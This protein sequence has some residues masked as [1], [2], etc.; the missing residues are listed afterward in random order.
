MNNLTSEKLIEYIALIF[1]PGTLNKITTIHNLHQRNFFLD[2]LFDISATE[3][4]QLLTFLID[5][6]I[7]N[8]LQWD[9]GFRK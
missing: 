3:I 8:H 9:Y 1:A 2:L 4:I 6:R 5:L 7:N